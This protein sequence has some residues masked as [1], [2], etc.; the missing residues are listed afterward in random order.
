MK[1]RKI[2]LQEAHQPQ[3]VH[4]APVSHWDPIRER[5][6]KKEDKWEKK[7]EREERRKSQTIKAAVTGVPKW[8]AG[9]LL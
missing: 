8:F 9:Q 4:G 7:E 3:P 1:Y 5:E 2:H 6:K